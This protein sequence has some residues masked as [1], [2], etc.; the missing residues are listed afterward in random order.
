MEFE[1]AVD[2]GWDPALNQETVRHFT[3]SERILQNYA[4]ARTLTVADV[5]ALIDDA[6]RNPE[7]NADEIDTYMM[8]RQQG[9]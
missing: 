9:Y 6:L 8:E 7:C 4:R 1:N 2:K 3:A 5:K